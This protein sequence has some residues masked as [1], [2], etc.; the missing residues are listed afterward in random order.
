MSTNDR[1]KWACGVLGGFSSVMI[2]GVMVPVLLKSG[3]HAWL[4]LPVALGAM[5]FI[6]AVYCGWRYWQASRTEES[7]TTSLPIGQNAQAVS[8]TKKP[9]IPKE[10]DDMFFA[11]KLNWQVQSNHGHRDALR[12]DAELKDG[13]SY[14][15][16]LDGNCGICGK[17]RNKRTLKTREDKSA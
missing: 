1:Y 12:I 11:M 8:E 10:I 7:N 6:G 3:Y 15:E 4:L 9:L 5:S 17:P 16:I 13:C 14:T 2:V